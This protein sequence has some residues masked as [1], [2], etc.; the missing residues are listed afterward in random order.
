MRVTVHIPDSLGPRIKQV[1]DDEGLSLSALFAK[2]LE[3]YLK[4]R[5]GAAG[6]CILELIRPDSVAPDAWDELEK[7]RVH[8]GLS[9]GSRRNNIMIRNLRRSE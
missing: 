7:G 1:A 2:G 6:N 9:A 3:E 5:K 8:V 4:Q